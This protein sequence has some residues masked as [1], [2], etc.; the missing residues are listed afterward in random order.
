MWTKACALVDSCD[1]LDL[2]VRCLE[3]RGS[4][5][6]V[7]GLAGNGWIFGSRAVILVYRLGRGMELRYT[8]QLEQ[9][10][11]AV[12]A[13]TW[14]DGG[15]V[16]LTGHNRQVVVWAMDTGR[17]ERRIHTGL[18]VELVV[19]KGIL[20]TAGSVQSLGVRMW[21]VASGTLLA[22]HGSS[23]YF[24]SLLLAGDHLLSW[25]LQ[26]DRCHPATL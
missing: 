10:L 14:E 1:L 25:G 15:E 21:D 18:V 5:A 24:D 7:A 12:R 8:V 11:G 19:I 20:I 23:S 2:G 6:V 26:C 4:L 13:V 16:L 9:E 3:A 22:V 17:Q